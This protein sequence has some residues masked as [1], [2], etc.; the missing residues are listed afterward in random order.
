MIIVLTG[1]MG[2]GKT[3][4]G[5]LLATELG[6]RF[7][8]G[9]DYHPPEN[10]EKMA[11]GVPLDD[12]DRRPWLALLHSLLQDGI[13]QKEDIVLAC[14]ALKKSY[15]RQLGI[16]Q[17]QI[18]S[19]F[20]DGEEAVLAERLAKRQHHFMKRSLL[21]SQLETLERPE[22]GLLVSINQSPEE[23]VGEIAA[24]LSLQGRQT[25]G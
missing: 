13:T 2:C 18:H 14:S 5:R 10:V 6:W 7:V 24:S 15:R 3:T 23:I 12:N 19:V 22:T 25:G 1:P 16:D 9:D 17:Q 11:S 20:L 21:R 4:I 8:D